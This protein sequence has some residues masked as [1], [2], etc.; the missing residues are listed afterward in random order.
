MRR[1]LD[2]L[3]AIQDD[4][5]N[6][7]SMSWPSMPPGWY[8]RLRWLAAMILRW[9]ESIKLRRGDSWPVRLKQADGI[10]NAAPLL[11][12]AVGMAETQVPVVCHRVTALQRMLPGLA[13]VLVTDFP[14]FSEFSRLRC[15][16]EYLPTLSGSGEPYE[17]R[18]MRMLA[19]LYSGSLALP[20]QVLI[21]TDSEFEKWVA[22]Q[23]MRTEGHSTS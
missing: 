17:E 7:Y 21:G 18:K 1:Y 16:V 15:L 4:D 19:R 6:L 10:A 20:I 11:V 5:L 12:W 3:A 23:L 2:D 22:W 9:A 8:W 13:P 14:A